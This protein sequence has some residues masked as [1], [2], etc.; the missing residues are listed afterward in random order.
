MIIYWPVGYFSTEASSPVL[1][2][3]IEWTSRSFGTSV[4]PFSLT[5]RGYAPVPEALPDEQEHR[6]K[7]AGTLNRALNGKTNVIT[8]V[9]LTANAASTTL[10]DNR[11]T[12]QSFIGFMP[13]TANAASELGAGTIYV[14]FSTQLI[15]SAVINHANNAQSDRNFIVLIIG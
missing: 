2:G 5:V 14:P 4:S 1:T 8:T 3:V 13:V 15:G 6:R 7:I 12:P 10:T 9:T 11:I